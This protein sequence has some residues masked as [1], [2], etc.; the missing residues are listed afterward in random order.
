MYKKIL[1]CCADTTILKKLI[2][3]E[4]FKDIT[5]TNL[6]YVVMGDSVAQR[7]DH[8]PPNISPTYCHDTTSNNGILREIYRRI[9]MYQNAHFSDTY[10][11]YI[12]PIVG[13]KKAAFYLA[14]FDFLFKPLRK[15]V[16]ISESKNVNIASMLQSKQPDAVI[17]FAGSS[18]RLYDTLFAV[19]RKLKIKSYLAPVGWDNITSKMIFLCSPDY[20]LERG[21]ENQQYAANMLK[22]DSKFSYK[23][24]VAWYESFFTFQKE[25]NLIQERSAFRKKYGISEQEKLILFGGSLRPYNETQFLKL[26]DDAIEE[27]HI[28]KCVLIYRPHPWRNERKGQDNF[29]SLDFKH[30]VFDK[31]LLQPYI[32]GDNTYIPDQSEFEKIY[33]GVDAVISPY[34]S[35]MLEAAL[36]GKPIMGI[37][38]SDG[39]N[40]D[41]VWSIDRIKKREHFK[42]L[43]RQEWFISN[44]NVE[45]LV[46]DTRALLTLIEAQISNNIIEV[47]RKIVYCSSERF[48]SRLIKAL[49]I[50]FSQ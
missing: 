29:L 14:K 16:E 4:A 41:G 6:E 28:P 18:S 23:I 33:N 13:L 31:E 36:F 42:S 27:G 37:G 15:L 47:A 34:S 9:V 35:V 49:N 11:D 2:E 21:S 24:G 46:K 26:I 39:I 7:Q 10:L 32:N 19:C 17:L 40:T 45:D 22:L 1:I 12:Q 30:T 3:A 43:R 20:V 5:E 44:D 50:S 38:C 25:K 48:S 8:L